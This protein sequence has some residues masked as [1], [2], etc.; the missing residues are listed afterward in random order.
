MQRLTFMIRGMDCAD[1]VAMLRREV[2]PLV[3]GADR[4]AFDLLSAKMIV[5]AGDAAVSQEA[6]VRAVART[7]LEAV[8]WERRLAEA[9][10]EAA[11]GLWARR[12]RLAM[13]LASGTL[14]ATALA[15]GHR[16]G[17]GDAGTA[18]LAYRVLC[19]GAVVT[20]EWFILPKAW[21]ALRA[22]RPDIHLLQAVSVA[23]ALA[24][25]EWFEAA[26]VTFLF[27][28]ALLLES[29]SVG[30][31][32]H[33]IRG[34]MELSPAVA[35]SRVTPGG[36]YEERPV[37]EVG[38]GAEVSVRPGER[39]PLDGAVIDGSTTVNEAP[40]TGESLPVHK[41]PGCDVYAGTL[42][43]EG[44][45]IFR[46][47]KAAED[48][49]L[50]RVIRMIEE[51]QAR[52]APT[53]QWVERF[54]RYYTPAMM[55]LAALIAT[56]PP[57]LL[58]ASWRDW[59]Y[60]ALVML[61]IACP[62]ALVI[63]TPVSIVAGLAS[64]A[65]AGVLIKGGA[66]LEAPARWKAVAVDKTGTLTLGR[67]EVQEVVSLNDHT[68]QE[69][70]TNAAALESVSEHPLARAIVR[71]AERDGLEIPRVTE[72]RAV[73]GKGAEAVLNGEPFWVG[74]HRY[75][76]ERGMDDAPFHGKAV[77]LEDAGHS[78]VA[79][80]TS[81]HV[82][83]LIALADDVRPESRRAM[84]ALKRAGIEHVAL[85]TGDNEETARA[86][87][88]ATGVDSVHAELLPE[89]KVRA[90]ESLVREYGHVAMVGDGVN[91]APAMAAASV[92]IAMGAIG[93]DAAIETADIALMADDLE[94]L[95]WL[96]H[97]ARRTVGVIKQ[98]IALALAVKGA[99]I[100]LALAGCATL[101]MAIAA[102]SGMAV[103]VTF[104]GLRLLKG[105]S[106]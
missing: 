53:E 95:P 101:W 14:F 90:V 30:R 34:L 7:G 17:W 37:G 41:E 3:G 38:A 80:G 79:V 1:E 63:S 72:F 47:T 25:G 82:C 68:P 55:L 12:G 61:V 84:D 44:A 97:H 65:R 48:T 74:S 92:G 39:I 87:G 31:A 81:D 64:A 89:D 75:I 43:N 46:V 88:D 49:T 69:V 20:G 11:P 24:I 18:G 23:G 106:I 105:R 13:C 8:P 42:N 83:G 27:A 16:A 102:D 66:Y 32:R 22:L 60:Q 57:M 67:P 104:N 86:V 62:C 78:V 40:I 5:D 26:A 2:E 94:R 56:A 33:A 100:A 73:R 10:E 85:V 103:L 77:E 93:S 54:A 96:I 6:I 29:W 58:G 50:A 28:V 76:H 98:N 21:N 59:F 91:D 9:S 99:F 45:F 51:A 15:A 71:R 4:L 19:V 70:L 52:R 36:A 35:R